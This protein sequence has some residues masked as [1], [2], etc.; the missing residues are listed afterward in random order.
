MSNT[1]SVRVTPER[2]GFYTLELS[3]RGYQCAMRENELLKV[4]QEIEKALRLHR[5]GR[6]RKG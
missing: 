3:D 6:E 1:D 2:K 5:S 4:R